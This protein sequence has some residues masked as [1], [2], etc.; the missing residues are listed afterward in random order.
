MAA[1]AKPYDPVARCQ[2]MFNGCVMRLAQAIKDPINYG[3]STRLVIQECAKQYQDALDD[4]EIQILDAKWYLEHQLALNKARREAKARE[5]SAAVAKRKH[6]QIQEAGEKEDRADE[7]KRV[8]LDTP[9]PEAAKKSPEPQKQEKP[10]PEPTKPQPAAPASKPEEPKKPEQ[11]QPEKPVKKP[12]E[13]AKAP[14]KPPDQPTEEP[15]SQAMTDLFQSTPQVTPAP[16]NDDFNFVS[17]FGDPSQDVGVGDDDENNNDNDDMNFDLDLGD[18]FASNLG[19]DD[20]NQN[21][22]EDLDSLLPGLDSYANQT[23]NDNNANSNHA[24]NFDLPPLDGPN[25]FDAFLDANNFEGDMNLTEEAMNM[26]NMD[27]DSMFA[28]NN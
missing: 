17:M 21:Q 19:G 7:A 13:P 9:K 23:E 28:D 8:K 4:C 15:S 5:E 11:K 6:D 2:G 12:P 20:N 10:T 24:M 14:E 22:G 25:E 16:T 1:A 26:E 3:D 18:G 27:F